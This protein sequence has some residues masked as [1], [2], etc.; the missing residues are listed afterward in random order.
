VCEFS[1]VPALTA[2]RPQ[3]FAKTAPIS[4]KRR[5]RLERECRFPTRR[6][7]RETL[8]TG[9]PGGEN[10]GKIRERPGRK[11]NGGK[12]QNHGAKLTQVIQKWEASRTGARSEK[13]GA[14]CET[15]MKFRWILQTYG[16][17]AHAAKVV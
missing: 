11:R 10:P 2:K 14:A 17:K 4:T 1:E 7:N 13:R 15:F 16:A 8:R 12:R 5:E 9:S 3:T 6:G